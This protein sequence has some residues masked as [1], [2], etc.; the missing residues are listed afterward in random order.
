MPEVKVNATADDSFKPDISNVGSKG[1]PQLLRDIPQSVTVIPRAV[2]DSQGATSL[3]DVL[4]NVPGI[5]IGAAEGGSIGNN[6]NLRGFS[7]RT[8]LYLDGARDRGQYYRD[9][10]SLDAVEVL[11]GPSSM[12]FGRGS[13]GGVINQVSKTPL[14]KSFNEVTFTTGTNKSARTTGDF[15]QQLSDTSA[16]RIGVMAQD[17]PSTRDVMVNKDTGLAPSLSLGIGTPT[18]MTFSALLSHNRDMPDYGLPPVNGMPANVNRNN[19]YGMTDDRTISDVSEFSAKFKHKFNSEWSL[20]DQATFGRYNIDVRATGPSTVGTVNGAGVFTALP[21]TTPG[22]ANAN[23]NGNITNLPLSALS[24]QLGSHDRK[25]LDQALYNDLDLLGEFATGSIKHSLTI[26]I[27]LGRDTYRAQALSRNLP[28]VSLLNPS[29]ND[30]PGTSPEITGNLARA[31]ADTIAPYINDTITINPQWKLV[32]GVRYDTFKAGVTNSIPSATVVASAN[33]TNRFTSVRTGLIYQPSDAQSYY[34]SY[35]TSSNP[36]LEQLTATLG[37]QNLPPETNKSYEV[38]G[39]WDLFKGNLSLTSAL[40]SVEKDNARQ[41]VSTGVY[42]LAGDIRVKGVEFGAAG[43]IN[44]NWQIF[45]GLALMN[46]RIIRAVDGTQGNV[47][48]N[49][50]HDSASLWTT[51]KLTR[52]WETGGG[53]SYMSNRFAANND[54]VTVPK[55]IRYDAMLTYHQPKYDLRLNLLNISNRRDNFDAVIPSDGGRAVPTIS[56][57]LLATVAYRF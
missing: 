43:R 35:G 1:Q 10:F 19:Y 15:N 42:A 55:F 53:V 29:Y 33:Q 17:V 44:R 13:T 54:V 56:R 21:I 40:F 46:P 9:I 45:S 47:P 12:L 31:S 36:S 50:P 49:V 52:D 34:V 14:L 28:V 11:K 57:T 26:G 3:A 48:S 30:T 23:A 39:K 32:G 7:A 5:T 16:W 2:M 6:I 41:L 24:V 51:Y 8:D 38:G 22:A 27:E 18:E 20:R 4:R 37:Q 25:I